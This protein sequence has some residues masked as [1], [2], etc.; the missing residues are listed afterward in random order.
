M[1]ERIGSFT[2][3]HPDAAH[4][5]RVRARCH[6]ELKR[7]RER[8]AQAEQLNAFT[9][10]IVP[11]A[12]VGGVCVFYAAVLVAEALRLEEFLD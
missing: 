11:L 1:T 3:L 2:Y 9:A 5:E 6:G 10:S 12:M 4:S 7:R 8:K